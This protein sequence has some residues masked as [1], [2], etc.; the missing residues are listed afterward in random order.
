MAAA[1]T[2]AA[3]RQ[4]SV[5]GRRSSSRSSTGCSPRMVCAEIAVDHA[6]HIFKYCTASGR[7]RPRRCAHRLE[8]L[9]RRAL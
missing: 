8:L 3:A 6:A 5:L 1:M 2:S 7:S 4:R 9:G